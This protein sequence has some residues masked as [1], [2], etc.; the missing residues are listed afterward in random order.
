ML[1]HTFKDSIL[2]WKGSKLSLIV[3]STV[4]AKFEACY[5]ATSH[6]LWLRNF[7]SRLQIL[8]SISKLLRFLCDNPVVIFFSKNKKSSSASKTIDINYLDMR[9]KLQN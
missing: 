5:E 3:S 7:I 2:T 1:C 9:E 6:V 8:N 4:E